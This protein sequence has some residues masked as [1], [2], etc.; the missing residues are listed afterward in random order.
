MICSP[1]LTFLH[2]IS[3]VIQRHRRSSSTTSAFKFARLSAVCWLPRC[4]MEAQMSLR[5]D[6]EL[7]Y[8]FSCLSISVVT[9]QVL[10]PIPSG[11]GICHLFPSRFAAHASCKDLNLV[12][13][14]VV[15]PTDKPRRL[16]VIATTCA[17]SILANANDSQST[18]ATY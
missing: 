16:S 17:A 3:A 1:N 6:S 9:G 5:F 11:V 4:S 18:T 8:S 12:N 7:K 2:N 15:R 10:S 13:G 14:L